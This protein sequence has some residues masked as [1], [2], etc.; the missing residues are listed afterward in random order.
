MSILD[1][2]AGEIKR[3]QR[4]KHIEVRFEKC[5]LIRP[6]EEMRED[7]ETIVGLKLPPS[8]VNSLQIEDDLYVYW[9]SAAHSEDSSVFGEF[10]LLSVLLFANENNLNEQYQSRSYKAIEDMRR[11]R[12][13]D[14]YAYNGGPIYSLLQVTG[15]KL[16]DRVFVFNER[17]VFTTTL[18]YGSYLSALLQ[19]RGFLYWQYLF[20]ENPQLEPY[21]VEAV[22]R[23]LVFVEQEFPEDD[24]RGLHER[25]AALKQSL[26]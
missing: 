8:V 19:T 21:E 17:D 1:S 13:F 24:Y 3:L 14:Y 4:S 20:C 26:Q 5:G 18:D 6:S 25:L 12:V 22:E 16:E 10:F 11:M 9:K 2:L 15:E 7:V 23:G